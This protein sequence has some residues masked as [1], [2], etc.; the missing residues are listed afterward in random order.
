M[1]IIEEKLKKEKYL[2]I[3]DLLDEEEVDS[4][5]K[6]LYDCVFPWY[7]SVERDDAGFFYTAPKSMV[8]DQW[9][10][11]KNLIDRG[12]LVHVFFNMENNECLQ[13]SS[14]TNEPIKILLAF[15]KKMNIEIYYQNILRVKAN[16]MM[17]HKDYTKTSYG[18]PHVDSSDKHYVL[19]YYVNDCD[20]DTAL[21]DKNKKIF[22]KI[23][24]KK[25]RLLMFN[26]NTLHAGG[27]PSVSQ[28]RCVINFNLKITN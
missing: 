25:G 18:I 4:I 11:D 3:D 17:Q 27:H 13:N 20:G 1:N 15:A 22:A 28:S 26:G 19:I 7:L 16:L 21:F 10:N 2:I 14:F 5:E 6:Q 8:K 12:H 9:K 23:S 24:P